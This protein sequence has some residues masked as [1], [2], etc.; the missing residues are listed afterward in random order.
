MYIRGW[1]TRRIAGAWLMLAACTYATAEEHSPEYSAGFALG[2]DYVFRG[3]SQTLGDPAVV[4]Y[5]EVA[6]ESGLYAY[7]WGSNVDFVPDGE[8]DDGA[9]FEIDAAIGYVHSF[10]DRWSADVALVRY[11]FPDTN[12]DANYTEL[13]TTL[14]LDD[15]H[16]AIV[17]Y[18]NGIFE[19]DADGLYYAIGTSQELPAELTLAIELGYYDLDNAYDASYSAASVGLSRPVGPLTVSLTYHDTST[20]ARE[21]FYS[22]SVGS[23]Y[24]LSFELDFP[25]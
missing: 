20:E 13:I 24:V 7:A 15:Q 14:W 2:S 16:F 5:G 12:V 6:F 19:T 11:L 1:I 10:N 4:A 22:L 9:T 23:R 21:I 8:P 25:D 17:G 18:S 3:V